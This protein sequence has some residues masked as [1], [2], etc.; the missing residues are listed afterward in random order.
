MNMNTF[1]DLNLP[2]IVWDHVT[3]DDSLLA[4]G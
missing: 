3:A 2:G 4:D 1:E